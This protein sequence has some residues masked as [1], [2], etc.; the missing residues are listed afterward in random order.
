[1]GK[2]RVSR[3][4]RGP[5]RSG[6]RAAAARFGLPCAVYMG[7]DDMARQ[8]PNVG[9]MQLLGATVEPVTSGDRTLS[10]SVFSRGRALRS[11]RSVN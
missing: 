11:T 7:T 4:R 3:D 5:A 8:A 1:M 10:L 6:D 9:R 2:T